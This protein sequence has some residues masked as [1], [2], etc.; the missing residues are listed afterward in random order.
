MHWKKSSNNNKKQVLSTPISEVSENVCFISWLVS[1]IVCIHIQY[2]LRNNL[3]KYLQ[4]LIK[5]RS[6]VQEKNTSCELTLILI[7][8][9]HFPK[10]ISQWELDYGLFTNL[11]RIIDAWNFSLSSFKLKEVSYLSWQNICPI[12]CHIKLKCFLRT[13]LLENLLFCKISHICH[14]ELSKLI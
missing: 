2:F 3:Q 4:E 14:C 11:P 13:R 8:E 1:Y 5:R 12:T 7:N 6:K 9:K 10:T